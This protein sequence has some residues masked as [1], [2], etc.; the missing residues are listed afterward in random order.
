MFAV[1]TGKFQNYHLLRLQDFQES[2]IGWLIDPGCFMT[3]PVTM[4][5]LNRCHP[6]QGHSCHWKPNYLHL[7]ELPP[8][9]C[10][11]CCCCCRCCCCCC[12]CC[13]CCCCCCCSISCTKWLEKK[14]RFG[15]PNHHKI[16]ATENP[17]TNMFR[18]KA[19]MAESLPPWIPWTTSDNWIGF[20]RRFSKNPKPRDPKKHDDAWKIHHE[21][22]MK[23]YFLLKIGIFQCHVSFY[24]W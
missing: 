14:N 1:D 10:C 4:F 5:Q 6:L 23:M 3:H 24:G 9:T 15:F 19:C 11:C 13:W 18:T 17:T 2:A 12:C 22:F 20:K 8:P 21:D 16:F 7:G